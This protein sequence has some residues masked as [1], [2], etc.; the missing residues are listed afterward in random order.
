MCV[1]WT[2]QICLGMDK[3]HIWG[4]LIGKGLDPTL[5]MGSTDQRYGRILTSQSLRNC[6]VGRLHH[7]RGQSHHQS[8]M[9]GRKQRRRG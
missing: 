8:Q 6:T 3:N 5:V 2:S 9:G 1:W 4:D 7:D